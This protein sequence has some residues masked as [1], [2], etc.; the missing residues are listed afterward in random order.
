MFCWKYQF[1]YWVPLT[2]WQ[3]KQVHLFTCP[4]CLPQPTCLVYASYQCS[5]FVYVSFCELTCLEQSTSLRYLW[6]KAIYV[7]LLSIIDIEKNRLLKV[8]YVPT[9]R[10]ASCKAFL[11]RPFTVLTRQTRQAVR[12]I[13]QSIS[14][15]VYAQCQSFFSSSLIQWTKSQNVCHLHALS[16]Q[17]YNCE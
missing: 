14:L 5:C 15:Y 1:C 4:T 17:S 9:T 10:D 12:A 6:S 3:L 7:L 8:C 13:E 16:A 2:Y 11:L